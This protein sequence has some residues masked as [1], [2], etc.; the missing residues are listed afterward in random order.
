MWVAGCAMAASEGAGASKQLDAARN[1]L[2][3]V[4]L[5][6][7]TLPNESVT[8]IPSLKLEMIVCR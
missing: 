7:R 4:S 8:R 6:K 3:K 1:K 5:V 2:R